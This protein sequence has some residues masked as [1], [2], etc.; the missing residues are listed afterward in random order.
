MPAGTYVELADAEAVART[1]AR[2][3]NLASVGSKVFFGIPKPPPTANPATWRPN[4]PLIALS[5]VG[6]GPDA[7]LPSD[8]ARIQFDVW[9]D[10]KATAARIATQ[11]VGHASAIGGDVVAGAVIAGALV[12]MGPLWRPDQTAQLARYVVDVQFT[13]HPVGQ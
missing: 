12:L 10:D 3:L 5:R 4:Y 8:D 1:W 6:G 2:G 9:A 7:D 11:L 13:I